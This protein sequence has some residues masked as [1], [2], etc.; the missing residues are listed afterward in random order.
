MVK[1]VN[2]A[3]HAAAK[4]EYQTLM[5]RYWRVFVW[6]NLCFFVYSVATML[7]LS[8]FHPRHS[9]SLVA[10]VAVFFLLA[11]MGINGV[12][13]ITVW[14][15][16]I[17]WPCPKCGQPFNRRAGIGWPNGI[18]LHCDLDLRQTIPPNNRHTKSWSL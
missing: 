1:E 6:G 4:E 15:L 17:S 10:F 11:A 3:A 13:Q 14:A 12:A 5:R 16:M 2:P 7:V 18:C 9:T 8:A